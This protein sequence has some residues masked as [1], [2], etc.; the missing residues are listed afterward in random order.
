MFSFP[1]KIGFIDFHRLLKIS[2]KLS[3]QVWQTCLNSYFTV[4]P[5]TI[6]ILL[7]HVDIFSVGLRNRIII[8]KK[9][10]SNTWWTNSSY[11]CLALRPIRCVCM[12]VRPNYKSSAKCRN[13]NVMSVKCYVEELP[14]PVL[15]TPTCTVNLAQF[16]L[17]ELNLTQFYSAFGHAKHWY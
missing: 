8:K 13:V 10:L 3:L 5:R 1:Y 7:N 12:Y 17:T 2:V 9:I 16:P 6:S 11:H 15:F 4:G 14:W